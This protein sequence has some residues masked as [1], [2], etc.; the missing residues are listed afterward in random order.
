MLNLNLNDISS[1]SK[2]SK[3]FPANQ[4]ICSLCYSIAFNGK[5]CNNRKC[6]NIFCLPCM[7]KQQKYFFV[8]DKKEFKCPFC[9]TFSS[10][11]DLDKVIID[12]INEFKYFCKKNKNCK[13]QYGLEQMIKEHDHKNESF[14]NE[15]CYVCKRVL[16]QT[17]LNVIKCNLC[18]NNCCFQNISY[19]AIINTDNKYNDNIISDQNINN[20]CSQNCFLC[21]LPIC[22]YCS[23]EN[24]NK[25]FNNIICEE[26]QQNSKCNS[27]TKNMVKYI[28]TF[29]KIILCE[30]CK[31]KCEFCGLIL[32][33]QDCLTKKILC[34]NCS[35][36]NSKLNYF[37][38]NHLSILNCPSCFKKCI[39]CKNNKYDI[40]CNICFKEICIK[41]CSIKCKFCSK[42]CCNKC[43]LICSIC[44]KISC[45]NCAII[46]SECGIG[47][48]N[49]TLCKKC[50]SNVI[51]KCNICNK[52]ICINCWNVCN[53]CGIILCS[54]HCNNC[55][56]CEDAI[57]DLHYTKC[58]KCLT[59]EEQQFMKLCLKKCVLK[60]S[61]CVNKTTILCKE[62]NHMDNYVQNFGCPHNIC[63]SCIRKCSTCGKVVRKCLDC[64]DYFYEF[65]LYCRQYQCLNCCRKCKE[66]DEVFCSMKHLCSLC[67]NICNS[68]CF[69]C[70]I[71][72]KKTCYDCGE[73]LKICDGCKNKCICS[74][75][76]YKSKIKFLGD[77]TNSVS[78]H[79]C[80][81]YA[82]KKHL[83]I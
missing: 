35:N 73:K 42:L 79:L 65:C 18:Y 81:M 9:M 12:Y 6:Q 43:T 74:F 69:N 55:S 30:N 4:L 71:I 45:Q 70:D 58:E 7:Q 51:Q 76:C 22:K 8:Q 33:K 63:N 32:C 17:N 44:K 47:I 41:N 62:Q 56:N 1:I 19:N 24:N 37:N 82:C 40:K 80:C 29:C 75:E 15:K 13:Q 60:C 14:P 2:I 53:Y 28:C 39:L 25:I 64:I 68:Q 38:C 83:K 16:N 20:N 31:T 10:F 67:G 57:C 66:C 11:S 36:L 21:E 72:R 3:I 48:G 23:K 52:L 54:E 77:K 49:I 34:Q 27:C 26:C 46:C 59:K 50:D 61:F 5:K 78:Y